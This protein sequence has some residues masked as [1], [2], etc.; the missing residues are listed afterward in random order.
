MGALLTATGQAKTG[1]ALLHQAIDEFRQ[2]S[3]QPRWELAAALT[4]LGESLSER[5]RFDEADESLGEGE[6]IYRQTL[7]E[8]NIYLA[9][10]LHQHALVLFWKNQLPTAEKKEREALA[11]MKALFPN[12]ET[13]WVDS[14]ATLGYILIKSGQPREGE[15]CLRQTLAIH[16]KQT[17][18]NYPFITTT[19]IDLSQLL[20]AQHRLPE[21]EEIALDARREA[22]E[23][24][25][26]QSPLLKAAAENVI[27]I[28]QAEGRKDLT[29][30][31][32]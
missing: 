27:K 13:I 6:Q 31:L 10:N 19:K 26:S 11:M 16:E 21:A 28:R 1:E 9:G 2:V 22:K 20:V 7:G 23:H 8:Q 29:A 4:G 30:G 3:S 15:Q 17:E 5:K 25:D 32:D 12:R 24:L 18:K 14:V